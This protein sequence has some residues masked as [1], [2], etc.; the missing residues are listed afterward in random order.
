MD[1]TLKVPARRTVLGAGLTAAGLFALAGTAQAT[2][3]RRGTRGNPDNDVGLLNTALALEHE[4]IAAYS[5]A[6][7]SGLLQPDVLAIGLKFRGHHM[8]HRD[9]LAAAIRTLGGRPVDAKTNEEYAHDLNAG[10]LTSQADV[11]RF[12]LGL[13]QGATNAYLG[14]L[15]PLMHSDDRVLAARIA[16][17][18]AVHT[19]VFMQALG[20]AIPAQAPLFG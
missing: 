17:D 6:G 2:P 11:L 4:G 19:A 1:D 14:M 18:E 20:I 9:D 16:A 10:A 3:H 13:E 7:G 8:K 12:A 5:I 15:G